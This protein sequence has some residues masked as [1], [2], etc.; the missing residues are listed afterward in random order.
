MEEETPIF[1]KSK[2]LKIIPKLLTESA[3]SESKM[4]PVAMI[5]CACVLSQT[6]LNVQKQS[7]KLP[8]STKTEIAC[9]PLFSST[10]ELRVDLHSGTRKR[11]LFEILEN[12]D[13]S[14]WEP[15]ESK[16]ASG[17]HFSNRSGFAKRDTC[18][19]P[20]PTGQLR[21]PSAV[22]PR[23]GPL[24]HLV[25]VVSCE[26]E[27]RPQPCRLSGPRRPVWP[28]TTVSRRQRRP[29][30]DHHHRRHRHLYAFMYAGCAVVCA[31]SVV[32]A[33]WAAVS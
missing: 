1:S 18:R 12:P 8:F 24:E 5:S 9:P 20:P 22:P 2:S 23:R 27:R 33:T 10:S 19:K 11:H 6:E 15:N 3:A 4:A 14:S 28:L 32:I 29:A 7:E 17:S 16:M 13:Q 31:R 21:R 30:D 26:E 25:A